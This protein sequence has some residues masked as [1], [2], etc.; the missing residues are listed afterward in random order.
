MKMLLDDDVTITEATC[1]PHCNLYAY[2]ISEHAFDELALA[3]YF[4]SGKF[5]KTTIHRWA[6]G[7]LLTNPHKAQNFRAS[8]DNTVVLLPLDRSS[9]IHFRGHVFLLCYSTPDES[10]TVVAIAIATENP[11][12]IESSYAKIVLPVHIMTTLCGSV[13]VLDTEIGWVQHPSLPNN[14][15]LLVDDLADSISEPIDEDTSTEYA[16][17][18]LVA[19]EFC[20]MLRH[21]RSLKTPSPILENERLTRLD[22]LEE[23]LKQNGAPNGWTRFPPTRRHVEK[24]KLHG[25][26]SVLK[27]YEKNAGM[28]GK[29]FPML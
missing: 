15:F 13:C 28:F 17:Q 18:K 25:L 29:L 20:D 2:R 9:S 22:I 10:T 24:R 21:A 12:E 1:R 19:R 27:T 8:V 6:A 26:K 3:T 16:R 23:H 11:F 4:A 5:D 14:V 7:K